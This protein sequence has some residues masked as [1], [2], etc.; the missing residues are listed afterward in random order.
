[1][2]IL[3][4]LASAPKPP[5]LPPYVEYNK[6]L[7]EWK[8]SIY[9]KLIAIPDLSL[10]S[11]SFEK[12]VTEFSKLKKGDVIRQGN[13]VY[14][15]AIPSE[16][17]VVHPITTISNDNFAEIADIRDYYVLSTS[18]EY[19]FTNSYS[20]GAI[21]KSLGG[22]FKALKAGKYD[23]NDPEAWELVGTYEPPKV[24]VK[25]MPYYSNG[26]NYPLNTFVKFGDFIYEKIKNI[27]MKPSIMDSNDAWRKVGQYRMNLSNYA[28]IPRYSDTQEYA[29][30]DMVRVPPRFEAD[31]DTVYRYFLNDKPRKGVRPPLLELW[32]EM[33]PV[34][35]NW[36]Y[37]YCCYYPYK[38]VKHNGQIYM[39]TGEGKP[40][41]VEEPGTVS[42][43][44]LWELVAPVAESTISVSNPIGAILTEIV[45]NPL[46]E[47]K[48]IDYSKTNLDSAVVP[49]IGDPSFDKSPAEVGDYSR[50]NSDYYNAFIYNW[51]FPNLSSANINPDDKTVYIALAAVV[52]GFFLY[53]KFL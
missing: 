46:V 33:D 41:D 38:F 45:Q 29:F 24:S 3:E 8:I 37:G 30:D 23:V 10:G 35:M 47:I 12:A 15:L 27:S 53:R 4:D 1:M 18:P 22:Y 25:D 42:G 19:L 52:G 21:V 13:L 49:A 26:K 28:D 50:E 17:P 20:V 39:R 40:S 7:D 51:K 43:S 14:Y 16:D 36:H 11:D 9:K 5:G 31:K 48:E 6:K 44:S 32:Q 2:T 34:P